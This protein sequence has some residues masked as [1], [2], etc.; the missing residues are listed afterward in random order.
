MCPNALTLRHN[1]L[2]QKVRTSANCNLSQ[3]TFHLSFVSENRIFYPFHTLHDDEICIWDPGRSMSF[4]HFLWPSIKRCLSDQLRYG[5]LVYNDDTYI[6]CVDTS[7][8]SKKSIVGNLP[9]VWGTLALIHLYKAEH[10]MQLWYFIQ[11]YHVAHRS[12]A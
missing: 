3:A 11:S 4:N 9:F 2:K 6:M 5:E 12:D 8:T 1:S 10:A 7:Y